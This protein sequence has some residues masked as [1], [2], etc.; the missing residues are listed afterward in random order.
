[1]RAKQK[2]ILKR[3]LFHLVC[4]V[5]QFFTNFFSNDLLNYRISLAVHLERIFIKILILTTIFRPKYVKDK[6]KQLRLFNLNTVCVW[7]NSSVCLVQFVELIYTI[8]KLA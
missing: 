8:F 3:M 2:S 5:P 1:M 6:V 7:V 4:L